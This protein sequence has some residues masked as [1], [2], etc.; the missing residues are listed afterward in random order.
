[1]ATD[2]Q[3]RAEWRK[4]QAAR[5]SILDGARNE[6]VIMASRLVA[7]DVRRGRIFIGGAEE[8][9]KVLNFAPAI[10]VDGRSQAA[11]PGQP[12]Q[13]SEVSTTTVH[14]NGHRTSVRDFA[15]RFAS[16][17]LYERIAILL[18]YTHRVEGRSTLTSKDLSDWFGLCGFKIP[19]RMDKALDNVMRQRHMVE[20]TGPGQWALTA[21][22][23]S[24]ALDLLEAGAANGAAN[25]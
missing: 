10:G 5:N 3:A 16:R 17:K 2:L 7:F 1:V 24:V 21:A 13:R 8:L 22:G 23:E 14:P 4:G 9:T 18:Y 6:E 19:A 25:K 20:R 12:A 15:R 11:L